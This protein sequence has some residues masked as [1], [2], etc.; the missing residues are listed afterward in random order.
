M[1]LDF[2]NLEKGQAASFEEAKKTEKLVEQFP[3]YDV[4]QAYH[5][6]REGSGG[7]WPRILDS[8]SLE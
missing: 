6:A 7:V 2:E 8:S 5:Q 4:S 3:H 1:I